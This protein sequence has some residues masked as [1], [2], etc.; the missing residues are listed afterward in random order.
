VTPTLDTLEMVPS[1]VP[2]RMLNE[3][4][5]CPRL[6][7]LEW[8]ED[9]F[10][11]NADTLAGRLEHRRTDQPAGRVPAP[12]MSDDWSGTA[13]SVML[14]APKLG[15]IGRI[16]LVEAV[17][18]TVSPIEVKKGRPRPDGGAW[19]PELVQVAA[20]V[21]ILRE[22]GYRCERGY[23]AFRES[24][25][26]LPV[27]V[28]DELEH[29]IHL[30]IVQLRKTAALPAPPPPL[31]DD[32]KCPRCSLVGV[33]LP[34]ETNALR[35]AGSA[36]TRRL[37]AGRPDVAPLYVQQPGALVRLA[38]GR[39]EVRVDRQTVAS[40][41]RIDLLEVALF[42]GAS[43]T[44]SALRE[45]AGAGVPV[46][47]FT[48]GGWFMAMTVGAEPGNIGLRVAQHRTADDSEASLQLARSFV[49]AKIRNGRVLLR[50]NGGSATARVSVELLRFAKAAERVRDGGS[51]LGI[52]GAA[53][54][55]YYR[56]F[57]PLLRNPTPG[58]PNVFDFE[59]RSR[60]PPKDPAN[61]V[62]SFLYALLTKEC[63]LAVRRVGLDPLLGFLHRPRH[64]RPALALDLMEEFRPIVADSTLLTLVNNRQLSAGDFLARADNF[65][66]TDRGRKAVIA[67]FE[68]RLATPVRHPT[69]GYQITYRRCLELQARLLGGALL[70]DVPRYSPFLVR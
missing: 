67:A 25:T 45:L 40:V 20:Q 13:R 30:K 23:L 58:H 46:T 41:R 36:P 57:A 14:D 16:D 61:A 64:G 10:V 4:V 42:G 9:L 35:G 48:H 31:V 65:V 56:A 43:I 3:F 37:I 50:R 11:D 44:G 1:L 28:D 52:E 19:P 54:R 62:L 66:L 63:A 15:L 39:V 27:E 12:E 33:C 5:Y 69:F 21:L 17:D 68:R 59:R 32:P 6:F 29:L 60:R 49:A 38:G 24:R 7:Y 51:L 26:R 34:D 22:N 53:A 8:V 47:H 2:V 70:G 55:V 18:G